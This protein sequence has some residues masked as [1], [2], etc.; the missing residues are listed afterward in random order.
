MSGQY[1][2]YRYFDESDVLLYVGKSGDL[3][4]RNS[5][6]ISRSRWMQFAIRSAFERY[7][8]SEEVAEAEREAIRTEHPIF[9][10][11]YNDTPEAEERL[12][13]YLT[14]AGRPDLIPVRLRAVRVTEP[15]TEQDALADA[16]EEDLLVFLRQILTADTTDH[17]K[18]RLR[19]V[20]AL[21]GYAELPRGG[22]L[23][24]LAKMAQLAH[25]TAYNAKKAPFPFPRSM[26][27]ASA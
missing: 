25:G 16:L 13:A 22:E 6:H 14:E 27:Q 11:Q 19:A 1:A 15:M 5:A 4:Q 2:L 24:R 21:E 17:A 3:A 9:N 10:K 7:C 23:E 20:A 12:R 8:T 18:V 26:P